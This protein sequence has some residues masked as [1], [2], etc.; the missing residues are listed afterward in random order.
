MIDIITVGAIF[1]VL[2][3][4]VGG[5]LECSSTNG[6]CPDPNGG[7]ECFNPT[8]P[9]LA[10]Q[11][12]G[13]YP[14]QD[15]SGNS[16]AC[17]TCVKP[18][19]T[20]LS[21][22]APGDVLYI[23]FSFRSAALVGLSISDTAGDTFTVEVSTGNMRVWESSVLTGTVPASYS[24]TW[25]SGTMTASVST[26]ISI[27]G[28][29]GIGGNPS[30][31]IPNG[32]T[33][34]SVS[35]TTTQ[36]FSGVL[37]GLTVFSA[38][39]TCPFPFSSTNVSIVVS[40]QNPCPASGAD[41]SIGA[42]IGAISVAKVQLQISDYTWSA[43][44]STTI[45][46]GAV[47]AILLLGNTERVM[48][49]VFQSDTQRSGTVATSLTLNWASLGTPPIA[50][51]EMFESDGYV[52]MGAGSVVQ[53]LTFTFTG[54]GLSCNSLKLGVIATAG[55]TVPWSYTCSGPTIASVT[56]TVTAGSADAATTIFSNDIRVYVFQ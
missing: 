14:T 10:C 55:L 8:I 18:I 16:T 13:I 21:G 26:W 23:Q 47:W 9:T 32:V 49:T 41:S 28:Q 31:L 29:S 15:A 11:E 42:I 22:L 2:G 37:S 7:Q 38:L 51:S 19:V 6:L 39:A 53:T 24:I 52:T 17:N 27:S 44:S 25:T 43:A 35:I 56:L 48:H 3:H 4:D 30:V 40:V 50:N 5:P 20:A 1:V 12:N 36:A 54:S 45:G 46:T 34:K 33:T